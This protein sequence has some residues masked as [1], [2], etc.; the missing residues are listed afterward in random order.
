MLGVSNHQALVATLDT[1][2][3]NA[4]YPNL[5]VMH[6]ITNYASS[7]DQSVSYNSLGKLYVGNGSTL[8][9]LQT[10]QTSFLTYSRPLLL[11]SLLFIP[12]ITKNLLF[13]SKL[14]KDNQVVFEFSPT[15]C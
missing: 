12:S 3:D 8:S 13:V 5:G 9:V 10:S 4:W 1:V 6:H 11:R 14:T 7:M 2:K 15:K